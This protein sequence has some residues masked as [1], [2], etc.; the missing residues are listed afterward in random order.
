MPASLWSRFLEILLTIFAARVL[1]H[2]RA[3]ESYLTA[4]AGSYGIALL[5]VPEAAFSSQATRDLAWQGYGQLVAIPFIL[6]AIFSGYGLLANIYD[7]RMSRQARVTGACF[8]LWIW[9]SMLGKFIL[10]G[11]PYTVGSFAAGWCFYYSIRIIALALSDLPKP[12]V[13]G[14][15]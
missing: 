4:F 5:F 10:I 8:G 15:L 7:W 2:G 13:A 9:S 3:L 11:T 1:G 14:R 12:G 6:K